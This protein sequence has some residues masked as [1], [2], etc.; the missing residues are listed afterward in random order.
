M[1]RAAAAGPRS[2]RRPGSRSPPRWP[3]SGW[4][5]PPS[6]RPG[7][8]SS[9]ARS[10]A[11]TA[12]SGSSRRTTSGSVSIAEAIATRWASGSPPRRIG[13]SRCTRSDKSPRP[14]RSGAWISSART[15]RSA[16]PGRAPRA[17]SSTGRSRL[18]AHVADAAR[19]AAAE[20]SGRATPASRTIPGCDA[21]RP[22]RTRSSIDAD[23]SGRETTR[24][25]APTPTT[26]VRLSRRRCPLPPA[27]DVLAHDRGGLERTDRLRGPERVGRGTRHGRTLARPLRGS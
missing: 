16:R 7:I 18:V 17:A 1:A 27:G 6:A 26:R 24:S 11:S 8:V 9:R 14:C 13:W 23:C 4:R 21:E 20:L 19:P 5:S 3:G 10:S 25:R 15:R 2:G 12:R 22:A